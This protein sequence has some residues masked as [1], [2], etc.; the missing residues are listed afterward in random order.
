MRMGED[1]PAPPLTLSSGVGDLVAMARDM[2]ARLLALVGDLEGARLMGPPLAIVNPVLWEIGHVGWFHEFWTLRR[3][4]RRASLIA[5]SD[6]L[7]D[8]SAVAHDTRWS[9]PLP[10]RAATLDYLDQVLA[11]QVARLTDPP[12]HDDRYFHM[13]GVLHEAMH[14]EALTYTR[15]TLGY[16]APAAAVAVPAA[17]IEG[18]ASI[19][20]GTLML[21]ATPREGFV[22]DNEKWAHRVDVAPFR[23]ARACVTNRD[24]SDFV[25]AG[26]YRRRDAW[27][28]D[29][30]A[31]R[32]AARAE[33]PRYWRPGEASWRRFEHE[34]ALVPD[35]PV[36]FVNWHEASAFC[37]WAGRRLPSEA[38]WE[39]AATVDR[40][41]R[42]RRQP[43]GDAPPTS[44]HANLD[45]AR[46]ATVA[47]GALPDGDSAWGCRQMIGN[48]WE[49]T[50]STF[51]PFEGFSPDPYRDYSL[52]WFETRKVLRGGCWATSAGI[53]RPGYRNFFTPERNDIIAGFRT[54]AL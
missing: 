25:A 11:A 53:A 29:G 18:D 42:R 52:P 7:Y 12:T 10:G 5:N 32:E 33:R 19:D 37:A 27:S 47:T 28:D 40:R 36:C 39:F 22:F 20:G 8:S 3:L 49:W 2:R 23:M 35:E 41:G 30:W 51:R 50:S 17:T 21:G 24:F 46:G 26:G 44:R 31:W 45:G 48:V 54:C 43:W 6:A 9:L 4:D 14:V 1:I 34:V 13:L 15:Q 38:E 16:P